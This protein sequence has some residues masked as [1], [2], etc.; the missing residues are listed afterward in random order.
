MWSLSLEISL[1]PGAELEERGKARKRGKK[2]KKERKG[3]KKHQ[4]CGAEVGTGIKELCWT[5]PLGYC[6]SE[7]SG[8]CSQGVNVWS[9]KHRFQ[10]VGGESPRGS[11]QTPSVMSRW[12]DFT[13]LQLHKQ[14]M[15]QWLVSVCLWDREGGRAA[16]HWSLAQAQTK[17]VMSMEPRCILTKWWW[18]VHKQPHH[19]LWDEGLF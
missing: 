2:R 3:K 4:R 18:L 10:V 14:T 1:S 5:L 16:S 11:Y 7:E 13:V 15:I 17:C 8:I 6:C 12:L 19:S 9:L